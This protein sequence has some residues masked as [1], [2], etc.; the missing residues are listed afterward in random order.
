MKYWQKGTL[1]IWLFFLLLFVIILSSCPGAVGG[2][3][4][5]KTPAD[6][7]G[8]ARLED[9]ASK[10]GLTKARRAQLFFLWAQELEARSKQ[11]GSSEE[12][13][14]RSIAAF[15]RV[16]DIGSILVDESRFNLEILWRQKNQDD[17]REKQD[18]QDKQD[19]QDKQDNENMQSGEK[20]T[21]DQKQEG[22]QQEKSEAEKG[23]PK[24]LSGLVREKEQPGA[25]NEALK[26]E[27]QR[28]LE[29]QDFQAGGQPSVEKDW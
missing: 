2:A 26:A 19:K 28:R 16:V 29:R 13:L 27:L 25:L 7:A 8:F 5:W 22:N 24:D 4:P 9:A 1:A 11:H 23:A 6:D 14:D 15:E 3:D 10:S 18:T 12:L 21:Q 20:Q 17:N